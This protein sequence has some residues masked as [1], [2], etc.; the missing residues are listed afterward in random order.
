MSDN[1]ILNAIRGKGKNLEGEM[2]FFDHLEVLRWHLIRAAVS[3]LVFGGLAFYFFDQIWDTVIMG[4]KKPDFFTYRMMCKLGQLMHSDGMCITEIPGKIINTEMAGQFSLQ[5]NAA[6]IMGITLGF[7][8]LLWEIWSF[9]KP[10]LLEKERKAAG[11]FVFY[12]S[13]LFFLGILFGYFVVAP[14]SIHFL[15]NYQISP[16]IQNTFTIDSYL[17]SVATLTLVSGVVFQLPII[18][19]VLATIGIVTAKFMRE[20]RRY[21]IIIILIIAMLVTP[22]PDVTT[23][24]VISIPLFGLYEVSISV[25]GRVEKRK[26]IKEKEFF[27]A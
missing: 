12:A 19:F 25:A 22:T 2:S 27:N 18:I 1:K 20:K 26:L 11:G 7:P 21:A 15:T 23:M 6:L 10:A 17:T 9:V 4:P 13:L 14:L 8:Y 16:E 3:I 5:I 24:I